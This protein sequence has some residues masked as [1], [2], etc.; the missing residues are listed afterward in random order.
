MGEVVT[1]AA[2]FFELLY[3]LKFG[4]ANTRNER[5][6]KNKNKTVKITI[7]ILDLLV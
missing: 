7:I 2:N 1:F 5:L 6:R 4:H 3:M